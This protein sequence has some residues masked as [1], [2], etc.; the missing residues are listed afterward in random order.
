MHIIHLLR[1][2]RYLDPGSGSFIIQMLL[3]GLLGIAVAVRI[4]WKKIVAFFRKGKGGGVQDELDKMDEYGGEEDA[5][6]DELDE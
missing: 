6:S 1:P 4:Y 3:A 2:L 5:S